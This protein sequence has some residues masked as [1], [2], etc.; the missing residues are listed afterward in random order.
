M[1]LTVVDSLDDVSDEDLTLG[2]IG[3]RI[4][5]L[6]R[7]IREDLKD[8]S[9]R[10]SSQVVPLDYYRANMDNI[11]YRLGQ[12]ENAQNRMSSRWWAMAT[13]VAAAMIGAIFAVVL[14]LIT[15]LH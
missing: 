15:H 1:S 7:E 6:E 12:L 2:E 14:T 8:I 9:V 5:S 11:I 4:T 3:R 13:A 10:L